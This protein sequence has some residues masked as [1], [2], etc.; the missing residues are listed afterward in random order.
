MVIHGFK[1]NE[2][3]FFKSPIEVLWTA[4]GESRL[5]AR[6]KELGIVKPR[7]YP[8]LHDIELTCIICGKKFV[9]SAQEQKQYKRMGF[10]QPK[11]CP[12]CKMRQNMDEWG[13]H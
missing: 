6:Q 2:K 8:V 10:K 7:K 11:R 9:F 1:Y 4:S 12:E 3:K 13:I 5:L